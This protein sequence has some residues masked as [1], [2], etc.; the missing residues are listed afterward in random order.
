MIKVLTLILAVG[1]VWAASTEAACTGSSPTWTSTPDQTSVQSCLTGAVNGDTI[2]VAPGSGTW[3]YLRIT[4]SVTLM[5]AGANSTVITGNFV[6]TG[7]AARISG[8]TFN[9]G[10]TYN[11]I[12]WAV[13]FRID[14]NIFTHALP[15]G[16]NFYTYG[17][18]A[19]P[20]EGLFDHNTFT[21]GK[22]VYYGEDTSTGG[23]RRWAEPIGIGTSHAIYVEDNIFNIYDAQSYNNSIDGNLGC[24]FVLRNNTFNSGR[25][26]IHS[27]QVDNSRACRYWEMYNNKLNTSLGKNY[28]PFFIRGGTGFVFH[29]T[30]DGGFAI[31]EVQLDNAR[32]DSSAIGPTGNN[33]VPTFGMCD[34]TIPSSGLIVDG[35]TPGFQG[36]PC[37]DQIGRGTDA[38]L[39]NFTNPAP[40][41][42]SAPSYFWKNIN[43]LNGTDLPVTVA[44]NPADSLC[45]RTIT[46]HLVRNRD[47][48]AFSA[49]FNGTVGVGEG[50]L[51]NRPSTCVT[52][53]GYWATDEGE[54]DS[55]HDGPDGQLYKCGGTN[56]W[57]LY[58]TPYTYPH[59]LQTG[60]GGGG[61]PPSAP[62]NLQVR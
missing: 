47:F 61:T 56:T 52:G 14:H 30:V 40:S 54:W 21:N 38:F 32:S 13:G 35:M 18:A 19:G 49:P 41:Q 11:T 48:Y 7:A 45:A 27:L 4:K 51:A 29:N 57:T 5:G 15:S 59:P 53:V 39:W 9:V 36:W 34:G 44:C 24:R 43:T 25:I 60:S 6:L 23:N 12:E 17:H 46:Y 42:P 20:V 58:Y 26:E 2:Y 55:T 16:Y 3:S 31:N 62:T 22:I 1:L 37:R 33:Q 28:R 8:F 10:S 50:P